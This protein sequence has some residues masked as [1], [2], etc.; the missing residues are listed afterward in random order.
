MI[1]ALATFGVGCGGPSFGDMPALCAEGGACPEGYDCI[2]GVCALPG[3]PVPITVAATPYLRG[4]DVRIVP[5]ASGVLVAWETYAYSDEGQRFVG[6]RVTPEGGVSP[7]LDLVGSFVAD[8]DSL[9]PYFDILPVSG[10]R[11][12]VAV[13]APSLPD[14]PTVEPRL[15]TYRVDLPPEGREDQPASFEPA[16][17]KEER[18][19]TVG[20]GAVSFPKLLRRGSQVELGYVRSRT[21]VVDG[22]LETIAELAI[23]AM[24]E[25]G[26]L[27]TPEPTYHPARAQLPVAVGVLGAFAVNDGAWWILDNE[28][29]SAVLLPEGGGEA[30]VKLGRLAIP[31]AAD[32][33]SLTYIEPS[34]RQGD[35]QPTDPVSGPAELRRVGAPVVGDPMPPVETAIGALPGLRDTPRPAWIGR[36]G[37]LPILVTPGEAFDAPELVVYLVDPASASV[38]RVASIPRLSTRNISAV[39]AVLTSGRLFVGW[40]ETDEASAT[41]RMAILPEPPAAP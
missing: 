22:N 5:Q 41:I 1:A 40:L 35:K 28:R 14:E 25:D 6:A 37:A 2:R 16:W 23:Y 39:H 36:E 7:R 3:T 10:D 24:Q 9:E 33:T 29:P 26:T 11:V 17:P 20:Y 8:A 31:V 13:S 4:S 34:A 38:S 30:E 32:D 21:T 27:L 12:L 18:L 15:V 19:A